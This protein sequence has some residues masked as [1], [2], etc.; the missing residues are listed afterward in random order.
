MLASVSRTSSSAPSAGSM[1]TARWSPARRALE[2]RPTG[3]PLS[4]KRGGQRRRHDAEELDAVGVDALPGVLEH[5]HV[6]QQ[7]DRRECGGLELVGVTASPVRAVARQLTACSASPARYGRMPRSSVGSCASERRA[8]ESTSGRPDREVEVRHL[9]HLGQDEDAPALVDLAGHAGDAEGIAGL[10]HGRP[11]PV[12]ATLHA[13]HVVAAAHALVP[14][15]RERLLQTP[16]VAR[17]LSVP[18]RTRE[19]ARF[20][21]TR[22]APAARPAG[23]PWRWS[24]TWSLRGGRPSRSRG[25]PAC[26]RT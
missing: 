18:G 16:G 26:A 12:D 22:R 25:G 10:Q 17:R 11:K 20:R 13:V 3:W 19:A 24:A 2:A 21:A 1:S 23:G 7:P 14:A 8:G 5:A 15:Q 4:A 6:Q 9:Q